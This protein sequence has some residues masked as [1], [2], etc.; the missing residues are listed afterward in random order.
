MDRE[1]CDFAVKLTLAPGSTGPAEIDQLRQV[2]F[3]EE[4]ITVAVQVIGYFNYINRIADG[5][6]VDPESWMKPD[7]TEWQQKKAKFI[8]P[9]VE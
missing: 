2:G 5:L 7:K 1:L 9:N 4:Q 8:G 6:G 3:S